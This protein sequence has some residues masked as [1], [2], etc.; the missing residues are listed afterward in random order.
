MQLEKSNQINLK[1]SIRT[2]KKNRIDTFDGKIEIF[3]PL[4]FC[5]LAFSLTLVFVIPI[6]RGK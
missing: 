4:I 2:T 3:I 5:Q 1:M 6:Q